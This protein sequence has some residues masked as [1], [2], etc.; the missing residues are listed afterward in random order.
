M[1][2]TLADMNPVNR[3]FADV[4]PLLGDELSI[5]VRKRPER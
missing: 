5:A 4:V 1:E 3:T 2:W